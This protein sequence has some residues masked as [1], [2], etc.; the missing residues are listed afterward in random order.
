VDRR[1]EV[2][3]YVVCTV[4][5]AALVGMLIM[6]LA[7]VRARERAWREIAAQRRYDHETK[8]DSLRRSG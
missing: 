1:R 8:T 5:L 2:D 3:I 7:D 6:L 4:V